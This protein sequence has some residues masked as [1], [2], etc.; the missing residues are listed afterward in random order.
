MRLNTLL[1]T[2]LL[3]LVTLTACQQANE[4]TKASTSLPTTTA[5]AQS[6]TL[7]LA[8]L[9][10]LANA[11]LEI[12][13]TSEQKQTGLMNR[14]TMAANAGMVFLFDPPSPACFWMKNTLIPLSIGFIDAQGVLVQIE[15]MQP[16]SF[17]KHCAK[18]P[19]KYAV[20]MNQGW[21]KKNNVTIGTTL[22]KVENPQ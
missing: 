20:E 5:T 17:D 10:Q 7:K 4:Q 19:I 22:L 2:V 13:L 3:S 14:P 15:D 1:S 16:Q 8:P 21:F 11:Q 12:A 6:T 18:T 9:N